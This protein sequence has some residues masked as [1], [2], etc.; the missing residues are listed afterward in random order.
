MA[1]Q[2]I[3]GLNEQPVEH[4][5]G[6]PFAVR[7][8]ETGNIYIADRAS[9]QIKVFDKNGKYLHYIGGRGRGPAEFYDF[10]F[11]DKT[12]NGNF[13]FLD[14]GNLRFSEI[15]KEGEGVTTTPYVFEEQ[16]YPAS[17]KYI[18]NRNVGLFLSGDPPSYSPMYPR[19][20]FHIYSNDFQNKIDTF[21]QYKDI[22]DENTYSWLQFMRYPG[23]F[24]MMENGSQIIY[25]PSIYNGSMYLFHKQSDTW[26]L[27][28]IVKGVEPYSDPYV[29]YSQEEYEKHQDLP[30]ALSHF[31]GEDYPHSGRVLSFDAGIYQLND[32]RFVQFRAEWRNTDV[33]SDSINLLDLSVQIFNKEWKLEDQS[34]LFSFER[35][36]QPFLTLVNWKDEQ[37]NFYLL[38]LSDTLPTVR[39]FSLG[40]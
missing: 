20:L 12:A 6:K 4:Q 13:I 37:D 33:K 18:D 29:V 22:G 7:T 39:K 38:E 25:S 36:S 30:G 2:V 23:S 14:R 27:E 3:I 17:V 5:L 35:S 21:F 24:S 31:Y 11:M 8:D 26:Q 9:L 15:T 40:L 32:E 28:K 1:T 10:H 16:Y 34:Y 19:E